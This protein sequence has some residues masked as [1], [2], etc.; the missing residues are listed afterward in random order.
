MADIVGV[1]FAVTTA[2]VAVL[3]ATVVWS[4]A[5]PDRR[6]WPPPSRRSWQFALTWALTG[7]GS[8]GLLVLA[9]LDARPLSD[10]SALRIAAGAVLAVGGAAFALWGVRTLS[11]HAALGL[12]G[13]LVTGGP[14]RL[15]RNP[16]YVG[17][18]ALLL[19][20]ALLSASPRVWVAAGIGALWFAL[21]PFAEEPWLRERL[22]SAYEEYL[23]T[24]AR[25]LGPPASA[26]A[27]R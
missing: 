2:A 9:V 23:R 13:P 21:A 14:Y 18:I 25:F 6:I 22:G 1:V 20:V 15:S 4:I 27:S 3:G 16:Q 8:A 26:H 17:D 11:L 5:V 7:V 12:G 19:G 24:T 10:A